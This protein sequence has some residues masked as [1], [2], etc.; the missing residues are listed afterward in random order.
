M[1]LTRRYRFSASHRLHQP[2]LSEAE[3]YALYGKC[4]N[5]HG[6][7]HNYEL[8]IRVRGSLDS[9]GRVVDLAALDRLV[10]ERVIARI[11]HKDLNRDFEALQGIV[12]TTENLA[13]AI[14][15]SLTYNWPLPAE[16]DSIRIRETARNTFELTRPQ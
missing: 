7:G 6:H 11:D 16:L 5:P 9:Y 3:N 8:E 4:N 10:L 13:R 1:R 14:E 12:P 15:Q 2:Q